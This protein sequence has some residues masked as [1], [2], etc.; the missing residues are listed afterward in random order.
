MRTL[1]AAKTDGSEPSQLSSFSHP[2]RAGI[3]CPS[4]PRAPPWAGISDPFRVIKPHVSERSLFLMERRGCGCDQIGI[5]YSAAD[6]SRR[7]NLLTERGRILPWSAPTGRN[8]PAQGNAL[9]Q[10]HPDDPT[11]KGSNMIYD[12]RHAMMSKST[13]IHEQFSSFH[14]VFS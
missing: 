1:V 2:F 11:L 8:I 10:D 9:G 5:R 6:R 14:H 7:S 12:Q 3:Y 13:G 4:L